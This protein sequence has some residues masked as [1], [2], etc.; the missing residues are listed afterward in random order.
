MKK[1]HS[2]LTEFEGALL[3][4]IRRRGRCTAYEVRRGFETSRSFEWSG[5][6]G[7]VYPAIKRLTERGLVEAEAAAGDARGTQRLRLSRQGATTLRTWAVDT[8]RAVGPGLDPFRI[9]SSEWEALPAAKR[10]AHLRKLK[11]ELVA[12]VTELEHALEAEGQAS[13]SRI[14]LDLALQRSRLEWLEAQID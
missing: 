9:R 11:Q 14:E 2:T 5:S 4:E 6:S 12:R 10:R 7:A 1:S 13:T 8:E 3:T